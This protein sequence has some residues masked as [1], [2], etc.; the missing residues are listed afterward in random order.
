[1]A[2][3]SMTVGRAHFVRPDA[4][5]TMLAKALGTSAARVH[6]F[7]RFIHQKS[8]G[9]S[10]QV[11]RLIGEL[12]RNEFDASDDDT[13]D[14]VVS[15][16]VN[17]CREMPGATQ[18]ILRPASCLGNRFAVRVVAHVSG[19][20][21]EQAQTD[22]LPAR[23]AGFIVPEQDAC[24]TYAWVH[25]RV[26]KAALTCILRVELARLHHSIGCALSQDTSTD[27]LRPHEF[28]ILSHFNWGSAHLSTLFRY[29]GALS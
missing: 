5:A 29:E 22:L 8:G 15:L 11:E 28:D 13:S 3:P 26:R 12:Q 10:A 14:D 2:P 6:P 17:H 20:S 23:E 16:I 27:E 21:I 1:M 19:T 4:I 7:A 24:T 18:A 25:E 9:T